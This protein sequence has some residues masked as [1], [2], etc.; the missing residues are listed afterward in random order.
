MSCHFQIG[1]GSEWKA[2]LAQRRL[3][4]AMLRAGYPQFVPF[5]GGSDT[6]RALREHYEEEARAMGVPYRSYAFGIYMG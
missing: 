5:N 2:V 1:I 6:R 3:R 4:L